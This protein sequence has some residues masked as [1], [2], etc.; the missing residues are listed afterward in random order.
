MVLTHSLDHIK[1]NLP[2][3]VFFATLFDALARSLSYVVQKNGH[4]SISDVTMLFVSLV[5]SQVSFISHEVLI[6]L[7]TTTG[8]CFVDLMFIEHMIKELRL[9]LCIPFAYLRAILLV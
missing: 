3:E 6:S 1:Y 8:V 4:W 9:L 5:I 2:K 7:C